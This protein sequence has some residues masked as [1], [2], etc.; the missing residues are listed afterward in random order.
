MTEEVRGHVE[1]LED[2]GRQLRAGVARLG[3]AL[4]GTHDLDRILA[5]VLETAM[6][7]T[8]ARAGA[9]LLRDAGRGE[10]GCRSGATSRSAACRRACACPPTSAS[11][12]AVA[13]SGTPGARPVGHRPRRAAARPG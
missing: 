8:G 7:A 5:V 1:A 4:G 3:D 2:S 11:A 12:G 6:A 9:V 13:R 10:L